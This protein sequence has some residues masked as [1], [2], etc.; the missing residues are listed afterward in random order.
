MVSATIAAYE[1]EIA[2]ERSRLERL[3]RKHAECAHLAAQLEENSSKN[4]ARVLRDRQYRLQCR[5]RYTEH[6]IE[7]MSGIQRRF[8]GDLQAPRFSWA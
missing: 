4:Q 1:Y 6:L 5:I 2:A 8:H 7:Q 3:R